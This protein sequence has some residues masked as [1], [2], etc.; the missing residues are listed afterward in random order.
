MLTFVFFIFAVVAA[1]AGFVLLPAGMQQI[2]AYAV[3]ILFLALFAI[4]I[5][6]GSNRPWR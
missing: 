1:A 6:R 3:A 4:N 5:I 2:A